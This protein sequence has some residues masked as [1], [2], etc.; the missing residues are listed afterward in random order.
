M[1]INPTISLTVNQPKDKEGKPLNESDRELIV[2][3]NR[4]GPRPKALL[5][6]EGPYMDF[7]F[8][9]ML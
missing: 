8:L 5:N 1:P 4:Y 6:F 9:D 3:K 2:N 7:T